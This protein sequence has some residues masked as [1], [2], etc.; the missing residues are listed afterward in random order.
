MGT[1]SACID[2]RT[3][4]RAPIAMPVALGRYAAELSLDILDEDG[5]LLDWVIGFAFDT[6][7]AHHLDLRIVAGTCAPAFNTHQDGDR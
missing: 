4:N 6:L 2:Q 5:R 7:E 1:P 3:T